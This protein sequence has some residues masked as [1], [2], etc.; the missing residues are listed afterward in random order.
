[1]LPKIKTNDKK[2]SKIHP[3]ITFKMNFDGCSKNNPGLAGAGYTIC[4][5][6]KEV[7]LWSFLCWRECDK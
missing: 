2:C 4:D 7:L 1:M 5:E 3:E 6:T